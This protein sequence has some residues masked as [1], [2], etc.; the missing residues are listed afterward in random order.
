MLESL[1]AILYPEGAAAAL[2]VDFGTAKW[3]EALGRALKKSLR[4][5][6]ANPEFAFVSRAEL[7]LCSLLRHLGAKVNAIEVWRKLAPCS[8]SVSS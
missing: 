2:P 1:A 4:D 7:G 8:N 5:K 6:V 3:R